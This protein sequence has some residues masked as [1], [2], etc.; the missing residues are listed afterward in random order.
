MKKRGKFWKISEL[1]V[2]FE[3][4]QSAIIDA[5]KICGTAIQ[6]GAARAD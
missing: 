3:T 5:A 1:A 4:S 6:Q 2:L